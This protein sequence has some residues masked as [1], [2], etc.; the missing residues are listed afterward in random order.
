MIE[1][2]HEHII[3]EIKTNTRTD[4]IFVLISILLN[5]ITM[6]INSA[7][8]DQND[9]SYAVMA[10]F[11]VL[12][13]VVNLVAIAGLLKGR[14]TRHKLISGLLRIYKDNEVDG[15]YDL[16]L[17]GTYKLR[18]SLFILVVVTT[19]VVACIVPFILL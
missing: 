13:V 11:T 18:Y 14:Q 10:I 7:I 6:A 15:Y 2:V 3:E 12:I 8:A 9:P 19:G 17:L 5:L 4:T 16:S 1:Y